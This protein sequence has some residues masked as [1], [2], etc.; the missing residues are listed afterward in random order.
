M[1][2]A[3]PTGFDSDVMSEAE[4]LKRVFDA[5]PHA[6]VVVSAAGTLLSCNQ[7][8]GRTFTWARREAVGRPLADLIGSDYGESCAQALQQASTTGAARVLLK[9]NDAFAAPIQLLL[10]RVGDSNGSTQF[11]T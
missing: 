10:R 9:S 8:A 4:V 3:Q 11:I 6:M 7:A 5:L 2:A 1:D